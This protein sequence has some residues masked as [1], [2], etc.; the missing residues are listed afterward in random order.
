M[1]KLNFLF[2]KDG[3]DRPE[4]APLGTPNFPA[5]PDR[6]TRPIPRDEARLVPTL[7]PEQRALESAIMGRLPKVDLEHPEGTPQDGRM[8]AEALGMRFAKTLNDIDASFGKM[9]A[10]FLDLKA[11]RDRFAKRVEDE[12]MELVELTQK[13]TALMARA[14]ARIDRLMEDDDDKPATGEPS[15]SAGQ[16]NS[17]DRSDVERDSVLAVDRAASEARRAAD[18]Q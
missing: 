14:S 16:Q 3:A 18:S 9:E 6:A 1:N 7:P 12:G 15:S 5:R 2:P 17:P 4:K 8:V 10:A 11:R 13:Q